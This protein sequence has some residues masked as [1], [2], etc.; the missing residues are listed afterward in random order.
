MPMPVPGPEGCAPAPG[1][2][3]GEAAC[4]AGTA[5]GHVRRGRGG[6]GACPEGAWGSAAGGRGVG[7]RCI[8]SI[9]LRESC[10]LPLRA[11][12][13]VAAGTAAG[14]AGARARTPPGAVGTGRASPGERSPRLYMSLGVGLSFAVTFSLVDLLNLRVSDAASRAPWRSSRPRGSRGCRSSSTWSSFGRGGRVI[15]RGRRP[16]PRRPPRG[17]YAKKPASGASAIRPAESFSTAARERSCGGAVWPGRETRHRVAELRQQWV[18]TMRE[19]PPRARRGRVARGR[20]RR[21]RACPLFDVEKTPRASPPRAR[22]LTDGRKA[23]WD[24]GSRT[25]LVAV[26]V[27]AK[28]D[29]VPSAAYAPREEEHVVPALV[30][31]R[32]GRSCALRR[33]TSVAARAFAL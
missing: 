33:K 30:D 13:A 24:P 26:E 2:G 19:Q 18:S 29:A 11:P 22:D 20:R 14:T 12:A 3:R 16:A 27:V 10:G 17:R 8:A 7:A 28:L 15:A 9:C 4:P 6:R 21:S 31:H 5:R 1:G 25:R 32:S 23:Q